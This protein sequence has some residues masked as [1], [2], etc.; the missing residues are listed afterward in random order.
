[1]SATRSIWPVHRGIEQSGGMPRRRA[2]AQMREAGALPTA[3]A[4]RAHAS[5]QPSHAVNASRASVALNGSQ[6]SRERDVGSMTMRPTGPCAAHVQFAF[7]GCQPRRQYAQHRFVAAYAQPHP[8]AGAMHVRPVV[9]E[10]MFGTRG[11]G[12]EVGLPRT[13]AA[14]MPPAPPGRTTRSAAGSTAM[15]RPG[16]SG[17]IGISLSLSLTGRIALTSARCWRDGGPQ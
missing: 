16:C 4:K 7:D 13:P 3:A 11:K 10:R 17:R 8:H 5:R 14:T 6:R 9:G 15:P 12:V 1:M 2:R